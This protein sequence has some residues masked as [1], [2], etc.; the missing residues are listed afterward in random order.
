MD[1]PTFGRRGRGAEPARRPTKLERE[2]GKPF[3][4]KDIE[5]HI[6]G[7]APHNDLNDARVR[8]MVNSIQEIIEKVIT[9]NSAG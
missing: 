1:K 3:T 8:G 5:A 9:Q 6:N 2:Q 7:T 4:L